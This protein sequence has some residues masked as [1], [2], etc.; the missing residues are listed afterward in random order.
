MSGSLKIGRVAGIE[1]FVHWTFS[2]LIAWLIGIHIVVGHSLSAAIPGL[3]LTLLVFAI[4]VLHELGHALAARR[5]GIRTN[6]ITLL[7]IGGVAHLERIPED[8]KKE[9]VVAIAGPLVNVAIAAILLVLIAVVEGLGAVLDVS[10]T[11][12]QWLVQL[13]WINLWFAGFNLLPAFPMDGGRVLRALLAMRM[14]R[15]R[16][17]EI[18]AR[19][20]QGAAVVFG[21]VGL[22]AHPFLVFIALFVWIGAESEAAHV[23]T[24]GSL[25]GVAVQDVMVRAF[26]CLAPGTTLRE[27]QQIAA[28]GLQREFPVLKGGRVAGFLG[29][30]GIARGL[31][32]ADLEAS[33]NPYVDRAVVTVRPGELLLPALQR[34]QDAGSGVLAVMV[35]NRLVGIVTQAGISELLMVSGAAAGQSPGPSAKEVTQ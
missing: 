25:S 29:M 13:F 20:G 27:A 3:L 6:D 30:D 1:V 26:A 22:F 19:V 21:L 9:L 12:G 14:D 31:A 7:P 16:A 17:T 18:A 33:I 4:I 8:P 10:L 32:E 23:R 24:E 35:E 5:Y 11:G 2:I 28:S 34:W 15:V